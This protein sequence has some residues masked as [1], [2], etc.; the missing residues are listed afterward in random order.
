MRSKK[1]LLASKMEDYS[2]AKKS[3]KETTDQV[4]VDRK[5]L[6]DVNRR[7]GDDKVELFARIAAQFEEL[8]GNSSSGSSD[9]SSFL[10][11]SKI[12]IME[13]TTTKTGQEMV[14]R[15]RVM[16]Q[17]WREARTRVRR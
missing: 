5:F 17:P 2:R 9:S 1:D 16:M 6:A 14:I 15:A 4:A 13:S 8:Q 10:Q 11:M 12:S 3:V 7:S